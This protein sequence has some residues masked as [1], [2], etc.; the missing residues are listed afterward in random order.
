MFPHLKNSKASC[1]MNVFLCWHPQRST[2]R[3]VDVCM[4]ANSLD[5]SDRV[6]SSSTW[7]R[8]P[9]R[10]HRVL[11]YKQ[12]SVC[13]CGPFCSV[14]GPSQPNTYWA[15]TGHT[16]PWHQHN[17]CTVSKCQTRFKG[18]ITWTCWFRKKNVKRLQSDH[19]W[20]KWLKTEEAFQK[21]NIS[22]KLCELT[23]PGPW[24]LWSLGRSQRAEF[25]VHDENAHVNIPVVTNKRDDD[26][27]YLENLLKLSLVP[28][29]CTTVQRSICVQ[30]KQSGKFLTAPHI[31]GSF[32]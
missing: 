30:Q 21:C 26:K 11:W 27:C 25:Q 28:A 22:L 15:S 29:T 12:N 1:D 2:H 5:H 17:L 32:Y 13:I 24:G 9:S 19:S 14:S 18:Q 31:N 8:L 7:T 3:L 4:K 6:D 20:L 10:I 16:E 23:D